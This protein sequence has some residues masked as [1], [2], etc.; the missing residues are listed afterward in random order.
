MRTKQREAQHHEQHSNEEVGI[1]IQASQEGRDIA[2]VGEKRG[3]EVGGLTKPGSYVTD[4]GIKTKGER[5]RC[6]P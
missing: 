4:F 6:I 5:D 2:V 3:A 1:S